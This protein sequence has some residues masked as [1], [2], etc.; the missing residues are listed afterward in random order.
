LKFYADK[1]GMTYR[2]AAT[3]LIN[4]LACGASSISGSLK[5]GTFKIKS[6]RYTGLLVKALQWLK[7]SLAA[8]ISQVNEQETKTRECSGMNSG[9]GPQ[10]ANSSNGEKFVLRGK[11]RM[12]SLRSIRALYHGG[13]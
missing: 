9:G 11:A 5:D 10:K 7:I 12:V 3:L 8:E 6:T 1:Y 2:I 4:S 13:L